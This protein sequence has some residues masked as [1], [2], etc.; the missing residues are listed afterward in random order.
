MREV[1]LFMVAD[2]ALSL[3]NI[4]FGAGTATWRAVSAMRG[5]A[6]LAVAMALTGQGVAAS[7][8]MPLIDAHIHYSHDAREVT[9]P[10][11]AVAILRQAGLTRAFVSS[12]SD[13]GTQ[14]L[15][16]VAPDLIVPVLRPY[17]RRGETGT[18]FR[19][20]TVPQMLSDLM[21]KHRYA[22]IG[23]FHIFGEDADLPVMRD[24]VR[25]NNRA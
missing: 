20:S 1:S 22:G 11:E 18:W 5:A 21:D 6:G 25:L 17:R 10:D 7:S 2:W 19:D 3:A 23:E 16:A 14:A 9:P 8:P 4:A 15:Y 13:E 12:S 24:V